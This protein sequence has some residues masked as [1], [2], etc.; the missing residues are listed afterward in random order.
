MAL[1]TPIHLTLSMIILFSIRAELRLS[2][3]LPRHVSVTLFPWRN[4]FGGNTPVGSA[5]LE[6]YLAGHLESTRAGE[7]GILVRVHPAVFAR[8][9]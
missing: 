9:C 3:I 2:L 8:D 7:S 4:G 6:I 5:P 1:A